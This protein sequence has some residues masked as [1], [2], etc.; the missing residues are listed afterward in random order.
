MI[1]HIFPLR[2]LCQ[3]QK[4]ARLGVA[5]QIF[6]HSID[7][8]VIHLAVN[9]LSLGRLQVLFQQIFY[10]TIVIRPSLVSFGDTQCCFCEKRAYR[11]S[12]HRGIPTESRI[13]RN[14]QNVGWKENIHATCYHPVNISVPEQSVH[15]LTQ[16]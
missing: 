11:N 13:L 16:S 5:N 8:L 1:R 12:C 7:S 9:F 10:A 15:N 6:L 3:E 2:K 4:L 14:H